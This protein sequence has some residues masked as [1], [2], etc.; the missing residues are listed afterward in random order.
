MRP[1]Q[2]DLALLAGRARRLLAVFPHPDDES[3]GCAGALARAGADPEAAAVLLCLTHGEASSMGSARGLDPDGVARLRGRRMEQVAGLLGL[4]G[5]VVESLPDSKL[6]HL[7]IDEVAAPIRRVLEALRPQV[8]IGHDPRGVNG[9]LDHI[10]THWALRVALRD[11]GPL[12]FAM[13]AY[14]PSV[15]EA[16]KPRLL[17]PTPEDDIDAVVYLSPDE[18]EA[19][20]ACLRTHEALVTLRA[21]GGPGLLLRPPVERYDFFGEPLD[22]PVDDLFSGLPSRARTP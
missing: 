1:S 16:A 6:A 4:D 14:P 17:F 3:Y 22:E 7:D 13:L 15:C 21:D 9:H 8:V 10:A 2:S 5:M 20:E 18:V 12:R 11:H 19:K